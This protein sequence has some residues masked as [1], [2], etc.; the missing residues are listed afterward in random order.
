[1]IVS[2]IKSMTHIIKNHHQQNRKQQINKTFRSNSTH[3]RTRQNALY[4]SGH[5]ARYLVWM[6][7]FDRIGIYTVHT[8]IVSAARYEPITNPIHNLWVI[9]CVQYLFLL[10]HRLLTMKRVVNPRKFILNWRTWPYF[11]FPHNKHITSELFS[12]CHNI[13]QFPGCAIDIQTDKLKQYI[14]ISNGRR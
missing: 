7:L 13:I 11:C 12:S 8:N 6:L 2:A 1:M 3:P 9:H 5:F 14:I 4:I 10:P